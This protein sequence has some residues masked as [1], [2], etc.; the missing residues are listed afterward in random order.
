MLIESSEDLLVLKPIYKKPADIGSIVETQN[1]IRIVRTTKTPQ[2]TK[3]T[4]SFFDKLQCPGA[5]RLGAEE[6]AQ[7]TNYIVKLSMPLTLLFFC[8]TFVFSH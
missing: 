1:T 7:I 5:G 2:I 8:V 4:V 3:N 6:R